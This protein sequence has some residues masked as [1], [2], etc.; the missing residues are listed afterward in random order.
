MP[1]DGFRARAGTAPLRADG[2]EM[3]LPPAIDAPVPVINR[4]TM[5]DIEERATTTVLVC[6]DQEGKVEGA[7]ALGTSIPSWDI[8]VLDAVTRWRYAPAV[9]DGATVPFWTIAKFNAVF[10]DR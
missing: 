2:A 4:R 1:W 10:R 7:A 6:V 9:V 8:A 5:I 3:R